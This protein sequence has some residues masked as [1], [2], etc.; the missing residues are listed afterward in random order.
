MRQ[1][2]IKEVKKILAE[3]HP[4]YAK[5]SEIKEIWQIAHAAQSFIAKKQSRK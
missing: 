4:V 2:A 1:R 5:D 3:D